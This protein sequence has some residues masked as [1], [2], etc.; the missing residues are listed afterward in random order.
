MSKDILH[1]SASPFLKMSPFSIK[2][3]MDIKDHNKGMRKK[4]SISADLEEE[5]GI[6][7]AEEAL[8]TLGASEVAVATSVGAEGAF[9]EGEGAVITMT[10]KDS[11]AVEDMAAEIVKETAIEEEVIS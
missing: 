11:V 3:T 2:I 5:V 9:Q 10:E 8:E 4:S 6:E 1:A 7:E